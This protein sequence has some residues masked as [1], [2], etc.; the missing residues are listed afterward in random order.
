MIIF[1]SI[2]ILVI[3]FF[4]LYV[5]SKHDFVLIRK[6]VSVNQVFDLSFLSMITAFLVGR[7][8]FIINDERKELFNPIQFFHILR[9]PGV[10]VFGFFVGGAISIWFLFRKTKALHRVYDIFTISFFPLFLFHLAFRN[11]P[12]FS[13]FI[14]IFIGLVGFLFWLFVIRSHQK[15]SFRD[16]T[17]SYLVT[18][19]ISLDAFYYSFLIPRKSI[20]LNFSILQVVAVVLAVFAIFMVWAN[21]KRIFIKE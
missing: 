12:V 17:I 9:Y 13:I 10:S 4:S 3:S 11:Y 6:N 16:G 19:F 5:L 2:P 21:Q 7:L 8:F 15:Y 20:V 18:A 1:L 14:S